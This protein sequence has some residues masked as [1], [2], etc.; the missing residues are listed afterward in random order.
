[1]SAAAFA[2]GRKRGA[3]AEQSHARCLLAAPL[4]RT[5]SAWRASKL[6]AD[7]TGSCVWLSAAAPPSWAQQPLARDARRLRLHA[8]TGAFC[9]LTLERHRGA[10]CM[11][12]AQL[13][14]SGM[15]SKSSAVLAALPYGIAAA[16]P[17][18]TRHR[19]R[20]RRCLDALLL[21]RRVL[22]ALASA[23]VSHE[24][25]ARLRNRVP[26]FTPLCGPEWHRSASMDAPLH[27]ARWLLRAGCA[28]AIRMVERCGGAPFAGP[29]EV[30]NLA[31]AGSRRPCAPPPDGNATWGRSLPHHHHLAWRQG[32]S[33]ATSTLEHH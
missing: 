14:E 27:S 1:V 8:I 20:E 3:A 4:L 16:H 10:R 18:L 23:S 17:C 26:Y 5:T 6:R 7:P 2:C 32:P 21:A 33:R 12:L 11:S 15:V 29:H 22:A 31:R 24:A 13:R 28:R 25:R 9:P 19:C 30:P